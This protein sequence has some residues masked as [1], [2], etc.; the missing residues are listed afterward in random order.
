ML[1]SSFRLSFLV[2]L[3]CFCLIGATQECVDKSGKCTRLSGIGYCYGDTY[4]TFMTRFC[5]ASCKDAAPPTT[6]ATTTTPATT[7]PHY[8]I[9]KRTCK[10]LLDLGYTE[11]GVYT[12]TPVRKRVRVYCD[13]Q[14]GGWIRIQKRTMGWLNY[15]RRFRDYV[16]GFGNVEHEHWLGLKTMHELT[17]KGNW[18][19]R[20]ELG[21][22]GGETRWAEYS[23]FQ[24]TAASDFAMLFDVDSYR[25]TLG[26]TYGLVRNHGCKF[27]TRDRD[28][29]NDPKGNCAKKWGIGGFWYNSCGFVLTTGAPYSAYNGIVWISWKIGLAKAILLIKEL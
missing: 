26:N 27:T 8:P 19:V 12:I 28:Q 7:T 3:V 24:I 21:D 15:A 18:T 2:I 29:D 25:G 23:E 5:C 10:E 22:Y 4:R 16:K 9:N 6:Q 14:R 20:F 1:Q 11:D 13:M 17:K